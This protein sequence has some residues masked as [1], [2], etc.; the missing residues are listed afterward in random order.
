MAMNHFYFCSGAHMIEL[1]LGQIWTRH[2]PD[3]STSGDACGVYER[4]LVK[5]GSNPT[6]EFGGWWYGEYHYQT[7]VSHSIGWPLRF[8]RYLGG[9]CC[10]LNTGD[11]TDPTL[12]ILL[13]SPGDTT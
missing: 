8:V 9:N 5:R 4:L 12:M 7:A 13:W 1:K 6:I 3:L 2:R 10:E 11:D